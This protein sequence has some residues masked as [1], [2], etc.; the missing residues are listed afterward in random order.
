M[1]IALTP[2]LRDG[3]ELAA[4]PALGGCRLRSRVF[5]IERRHV[6]RVR[7]D[8]HHDAI[9]HACVSLRDACPL[10]HA[11]S[12]ACVSLRDACPLHRLIYQN[13]ET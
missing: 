4:V 9:S 8:E 2:L 13:G 3:S 10:H 12:H 11:I 1:C 7:K 6:S 5:E